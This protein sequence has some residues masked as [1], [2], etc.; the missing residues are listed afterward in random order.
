MPELPTYPAARV[1]DLMDTLAGVSFPDP[2]RWLEQDNDEVRHWQRAQA[3][4]A[5]SY[6]RQWPHFERLRQLVMRFSVDRRIVLPR[7][8]AGRWFRMRIPPG[9]SQAQALVSD[10][11]MGEG[12]VL[13]DPRTENPPRPPFL[14]WISPSPDGRT[15]AL[16]VCADGSESNTI[17][18]VDV[19]TGSL[20]P[21]PPTH[22]LMDNWTGG[23]QWLA[24][25]GGFFFTAIDGSA[26]DFAATVYLHR[27]L[28]EPTTIA[29]NIPWT[30]SRSYRMVSVS[31]DGRYAV[32]TERLQN[33][34]PV[35]TARLGEDTLQWRPFITGT[36]GTVAGHVIGDSYVAV[37]DVG[38]HRGRLVSIPLEAQNAADPSHWKELVPESEAVLRTVTPVGALLYLTEFVDTYARVRVFNT[39]EHEL[40]PMQ[41]PGLGAIGELPF[42][43]M[44]LVP[45]GHPS[46]FI[47]S[48][49]SPTVSPGIYA[50][51]PRDPGTLQTLQ[52][53]FVR[54][55]DCVVEDRWAVSA[56][57][58][59]VPYHLIRRADCDIATPQATLIHAYG[60]FN[61]ASLPEFPG[62]MAALL[63]SGAVLIQAHLRG[64]AE[65]GREWWHGGRMRNKQSCY[66]D[67][68]AVAEDLIARGHSTPALLAVCG[69][70]NGGLMAAVAATQRP[71]LWAVAVPRVPLLDLVGA[72][73]EPYGRWAISNELA[74]VQ[75]AGE[76]QRLASFSPY[77][78]MR[79]GVRYPAIFL[80]AGDTDPR[81]PPWHARKFAARMQALATPR[82]APVLVHIW[83]HAGHGWATDRKLAIEENTEW[84]AFTLLHL[85]QD[86]VSY[87]RTTTM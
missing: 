30:G 73:R 3:E 86:G 14:S 34:I 45:R 78:L 2:Y 70:S 51:D 38:A 17:R 10:E 56:D 61:V 9:A 42:P 19:A 55:E 37:T 75:D 13:F 11:P 48:F 7:Y 76:V 66:D 12:R 71:D 85:G 77:H 46:K 6:V 33:P 31:R 25:S 36:D 32:A 41:L 20:I 67:L 83:E 44:N 79:A 40:H 87:A 47:F 18:L 80:D 53:P 74:D 15:L 5:S 64:G 57:G 21:D 4:L 60:G 58:T 26:V 68:Y 23:V 29:L 72:C 54:L 8:A 27:R 49:S 62:A 69:A 84:L 16:G 28:P 52:N 35:A 59:R 39:V 81:C 24:D 65:F 63:A 1:D 50:H 22:T 82:S 43:I